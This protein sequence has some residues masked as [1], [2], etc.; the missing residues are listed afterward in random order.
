MTGTTMRAV[1][2]QALRIDALRLVEKPVPQPQRSEILVQVQA[3]SL[4]YRD[5]VLLKGI[6]R[7]DLKLPYVP[8]SDGAGDVVAVGEGVT[9]FKSGD[10]VIPHYTQGWIDGRPTPEQRVHC[11]LGVPLT[12]LLQDY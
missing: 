5:L 7:P 12:G 1:E 9:R 6:Y 8:L 3:A 11:T 4:N 2:A 10:R